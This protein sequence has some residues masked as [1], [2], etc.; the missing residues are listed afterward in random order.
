MAYPTLVPTS[1]GFDVGDYPVKVFKAQS[2]AE[3]RILYGSKRTG[4]KMELSYEN[5]SDSQAD[6]FV[7]H[8]D[9][10]LGSYGTFMLPSAVTKGW[11]GLSTAIDATNTGSQWRYAEPPQITNVRP[12]RSSVQIKLIGAL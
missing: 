4:M 8:F 12:G 1:R 7:A 11:S 9:E 5:V 2:G 6:D 10:A 3:V